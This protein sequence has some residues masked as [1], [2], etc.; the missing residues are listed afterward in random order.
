MM[1]TE[2][3]IAP[4][5]FKGPFNLHL[6][7]SSGQT[8]QP[9]WKEDK[10]YFQELVLVEG[11]PCL[12]KI[13]HEDGDPEGGVNVIYESPEEM[14][15]KS[16]EAKVREIFGLNDDLNQLYNF[17]RKDPNLAPAIDFCHGLRLF[18]AQDPFE[19][20]ISSIS[21]ANCSIIRWT[22]SIQD[23][24]LKWGEAY[25]FSSGNFYDFP[26]PKVLGEVPEHDLEEMQRFEDD[27][28]GEFVFENN[29][30]ACGVGYRAK[31]IIQ[32]AK[33][34]QKEI[35]LDK[36]GKMEYEKAFNSI[37]DIPGVG[38]KVADCILLYGFGKREAF[39]ADVWINRIISYL[40][41]KGENKKPAEVRAFGRENFGDHAG[42]VQLYLFHYARN[43]GL[44]D[45]LKGL[46]LKKH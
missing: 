19:C 9:P 13:R 44:L 31:Y 12:V 6:T 7:I 5:N 30:Q 42:Y 3:N 2:F 4:E 28:P 46:A 14:L 43:S 1:K 21:S 36:L 11:K 16:I 45:K 35:N 33:M 23:I 39:P 41:F 40:Y 18:K 27:L 25:Q 34:V 29:L 37:L 17:F 8:S 32:A 22:R 15:E 10:G 24:K 38:P 26:S 20:V